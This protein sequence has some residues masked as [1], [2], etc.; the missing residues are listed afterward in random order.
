MYVTVHT[1]T[2][3]SGNQLDLGRE[4]QGLLDEVASIAGFRAYYMVDG[5]DSVIASVAVFD[6]PEGMEECDR[7]AARFAE[8]GFTKF[9]LSDVS[10]T[11]GPVLASQTPSAADPAPAGT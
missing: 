2:I 6:T 11:E 8:E 5:G 9:Q 7:R 10:V 3:G 1:Y 4:A